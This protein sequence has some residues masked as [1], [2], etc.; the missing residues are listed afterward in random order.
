MTSNE[1]T[2][3]K[4]KIKKKEKEKKNNEA[5]IIEFHYRLEKNITSG[6]KR[7]VCSIYVRY[8]SYEKIERNRT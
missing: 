6:K 1:K 4:Q 2:N 5:E 8:C 7:L 3:K